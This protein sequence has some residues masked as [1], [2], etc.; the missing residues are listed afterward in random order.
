MTKKENKTSVLGINAPGPKLT[1]AGYWAIT[2]YILLPLFLML[3]LLDFAGYLVARYI[4]DSCYGVLC[5]L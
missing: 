1:A 5:W 4:F 3:L 2:K